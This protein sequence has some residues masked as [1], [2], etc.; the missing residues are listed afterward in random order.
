MIRTTLVVLLAIS[1]GGFVQSGILAKESPDNIKF[2]AVNDPEVLK[3]N[4]TARRRLPEFVKAFQSKAG[5]GFNVKIAFRDG[6]DTEHMWVKVSKIDGA[7]IS[8]SLNS[9]PIQ[10]KNIKAGDPVSLNQSQ[11]EDW[12]Y[13]DR[14]G[15]RQ[16]LFCLPALRNKENATGK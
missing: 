14:A 3:A 6:E 10:V 16:G 11:V 7:T 15:K 5:Q 8:G 9:D 1:L 4:A 2:R 12:T 13:T